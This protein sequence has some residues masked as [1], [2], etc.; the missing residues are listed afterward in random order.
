[1]KWFT[2]LLDLFSLLNKFEIWE[3]VS[4][5]TCGEIDDA[6]KKI[7]IRLFDQLFVCT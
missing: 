4:I 3:T 1:M 7:V 2:L 5:N 6:A